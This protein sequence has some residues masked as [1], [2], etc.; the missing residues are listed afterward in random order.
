MGLKTL[1][2]NGTLFLGAGYIFQAGG[3]TL[4]TTGV[5]A[6]LNNQETVIGP[7]TSKEKSLES[8]VSE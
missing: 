1:F 2:L 3:Y 8:K 5:V 7:D 6:L 4:L